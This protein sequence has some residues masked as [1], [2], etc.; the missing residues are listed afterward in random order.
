MCRSVLRLKIAL[1]PY[2]E[3]S[4][5]ARTFSFFDLSSQYEQSGFRFGAEAPL[6]EG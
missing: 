5:L 3:P 1:P 6:Q 4:Q 2:Y